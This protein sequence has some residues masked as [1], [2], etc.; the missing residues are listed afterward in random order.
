MA[1]RRK[2]PSK[3]DLQAVLRHVGEHN[4]VPSDELRRWMMETFD[5]KKRAAKDAL[6]VL[7]RGGWLT[8][9]RAE[10][11][12]RRSRYSL[13]EKGREDTVG[14]FGQGALMRGRRYYSTCLSGAGR[15]RQAARRQAA[16]N[17]LAETLEAEARSLFGGLDTVELTRQF[18]AGGG[19][20]TGKRLHKRSPFRAMLRRELLGENRPE[21]RSYPEP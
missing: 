18:I 5:C 12:R 9:S 19:F 16:E 15:R 14:I 2:T 20:G 8:K 4:V 1:A 10:R 11:D 21:S 7:V 3:I 6:S 13:T 17:P